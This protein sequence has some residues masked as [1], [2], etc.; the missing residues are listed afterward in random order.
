MLL[1]DEAELVDENEWNGLM[2]AAYRGYKDIVQILAPK[3][4]GKANDG[5]NLH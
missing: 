1:L 2:Y 3:L 4:M 5:N